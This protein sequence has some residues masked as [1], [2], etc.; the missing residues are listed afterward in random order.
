MKRIPY[1]VLCLGVGACITA[2]SCRSSH[3]TS[4]PVLAPTTYTTEQEW[5][6]SDV[7]NTILNVSAFAKHEPDPGPVSRVTD[8]HIASGLVLA[9]FSIDRGPQ[10]YSLDVTEYLWAPAAF[11]PMARQLM[12]EGA[13]QPVSADD[14]GL[15]AALTD[16]TAEAIQTRNVELSRLMR[17]SPRAAALHERAA[18]LL[19]ALAFRE[20]ASILSDP[21]RMMCRMT[22]HLAIAKALDPAAETTDGRLAT[23]VLAV[24]ANR[25]R[26]AIERIDAL[27]KGDASPA[28]AAW[29]RALR[30]RVTQDWRLVRDLKAATLLEQRETIRAAHMAVGDSRSMGMLDIVGTRDVPDWGR[31]IFHESPSVEAGNRFAGTTVS[32]ELSDALTVRAMFPQSIASDDRIAVVAALNEE[33]QAGP[34]SRTPGGGFWIIDWGTWAASTQRHL[35]ADLVCTSRHLRKMVGLPEDAAAFDTKQ[36]DAFGAL[37]LYPLVAREIAMDRDDPAVYTAA[38]TAAGELAR[39]RPDLVTDSVWSSLRQQPAFAAVPAGIPLSPSWFA[40]YFPIGTAFDSH[41]LYMGHG[42][43]VDPRA[44]EGLR[45]IAPYDRDIVLRA[46]D[47]KYGQHATFEILQRELGGMAAYDIRA[48]WKIAR[49]GEDRPDV[50]VPFVRNLAETM[51]P[52]D[53][54]WV[55]EYLAEHGRD[56]EADAAFERYRHEARDQVGISDRADWFVMRLLRTGELARALAIARDAAEAYSYDGLVIYGAALDRTGQTRQAE[57]YYRKAAERYERSNGPLLAFLMRHQA[58]NIDYAREA[59]ELGAKVFPGGMEKVTASSISGPP[60]AGLR[61]S[62]VGLVGAQEGLREKDVL[63][64]LDGTRI[65]NRSQYAAITGQSWNPDMRFLVWRDG[66]YIEIPTRLRHR[67]VVSTLETYTKDTKGE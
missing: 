62:F 55:A 14:G 28:M 54:Y 48:A 34:A 46:I 3:P 57:A 1:L 42:L 9:R 64:G 33:P 65:R 35:V 47:S 2:G 41:R 61:L 10:R 36:R 22:A 52:D 43:R 27:E 26:E 8:L 7:A 6:V 21:R 31:A 60:D 13:S 19:G 45:A 63:V 18:L 56:S 25:Q 38:A 37:R 66:R 17:E 20:D 59:R 24:L 53:W 29:T 23:A 44:L 58:E 51:D 12:G 32:E 16:P 40:P 11:V 39:L 4:A 49:A 67:W 50:Y 30:I 5:L 15:L